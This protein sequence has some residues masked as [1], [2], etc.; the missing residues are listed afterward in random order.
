M[1]T[2]NKPIKPGV[3]VYRESGSEIKEH[4]IELV[5]NKY[6]YVEGARWPINKNT[7]MYNSN[8]YPQLDIQ[9][10]LNKQDILDKKERIMH[11]NYIRSTLKDSG[12]VRYSLQVLREIANILTSN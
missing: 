8:L 11:L 7:L 5:G 6:F 4:K 1:N 10:Y 9:Y 12:D 2:T 3:T